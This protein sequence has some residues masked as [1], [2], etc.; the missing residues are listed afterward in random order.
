MLQFENTIDIQK[1]VDEVFAFVA[2]FE[3]VPRWNY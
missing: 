3:N 1:P 2:D